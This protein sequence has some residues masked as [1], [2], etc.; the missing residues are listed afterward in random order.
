MLTCFSALLFLLYIYST[1]GTVTV[2]DAQTMVQLVPTER[3]EWIAKRLGDAT[4]AGKLR[5][6]NEKYELFLNVTSASEEELI[7][8]FSD[9]VQAHKLRD[10]QSTFGEIAY[11]ILSSLG[12]DNKFYRRLVI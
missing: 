3:L 4:L 11:D 9:D 12:R 5:I 6:L 8:V 7:E 1:K 10:E 2:E